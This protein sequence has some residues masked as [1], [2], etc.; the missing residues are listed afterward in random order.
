MSQREAG[1]GKPHCCHGWIWVGRGSWESE[2]EHEAI[3]KFGTVAGYKNI[4]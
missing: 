1:G 4:V 3:D 2:S